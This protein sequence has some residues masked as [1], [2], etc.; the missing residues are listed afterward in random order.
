MASRILKGAV[1]AGLVLA[2]A[3]NAENCKEAVLYDGSKINGQMEESGRTFPEAPE[4]RANWG[5]FTNMKAPYMRLSGIKNGAGDWTGTLSL[6]GLPVGVEG[7]TFSIT[8][9][10]TQNAKFGVWLAGSTGTG[11]IVFHTLKAN[12]TQVITV[13]VRD[14]LGSTSATVNKVGFGLFG[15]PA[16]QYTTLFVDNIKLSCTG[17]AQAGSTGS[18]SV[19]GGA[20]AGNGEYAFRDV[21]PASSVRE[22]D[23]EPLPDAKKALNEETRREYSNRTARQFVLTEHEHQQVTKFQTASNL[24]PEGSRNGW[25]RS[26]FTIDRNRLK[27]SVIASPKN[28]FTEAGEIA[29][30]TGNRTIPVLV[31]DLDY[32]VRYFTDTTFQKTEL[33]DFHLLLAGFPVSVAGGSRI[34]FVYDPFFVATTRSS[35]PRMEICV[36]SKCQA[37]SPKTGMDFEFDSA[38]EQTVVVKLSSD[39]VNTQQNLKLE[40]K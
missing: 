27:D 20:S 23:A 7:G 13:N 33:E 16:Y 21:N 25:Y 10:S 37:V 9:R 31:A 32:A 5:D 2:S 3:G 30:A 17:G 26:M 14:L 11:N 8:A 18:G 35:L 15:V 6:Q 19:T 38:G 39:N 4:W 36:K 28:L 12:S 34:K 29:A 40:V 24:T 22:F 1:F